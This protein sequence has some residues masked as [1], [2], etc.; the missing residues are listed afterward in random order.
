[1]DKD[2]QFDISDKTWDLQPQLMWADLWEKK[3]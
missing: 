3:Q 2:V 1:M